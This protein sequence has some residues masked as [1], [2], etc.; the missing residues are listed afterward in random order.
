MARGGIYK[1]EVVRARRQLLAQGRYPSIDAIR[2][3]LG[4]TGSKS[5]IQKYLKEIEEDEGGRATGA[6]GLSEAIQGLSARLAEQLQ[7]E[8]DQR[9]MELQTRHA[10]EL[11]EARESAAAAQKDLKALTVTL[12]QLR[13]AVAERDRRYDELSGRYTGEVQARAQAQQLA[14]DVHLQLEAESAFRVSLETKYADA[15]RALEHFREAAKE[16]RDAES[17]KHQ[18]QLEYFQVEMRRLQLAL[19]EAQSTCARANEER[20]RLTTELATARREVS[21]FEATRGQLVSTNEKL[22]AAL[23]E[24]DAARAALAAERNRTDELTKQAAANG[25]ELRRLSNLLS[26]KEAEVAAA[27]AREE[28]VEQMQMRFDQQLKAQLGR[29]LRPGA[30]KESA[31]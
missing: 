10:E 1:S 26:E 21:Q 11:R 31:V 4:N 12:E 9:V 29:L 17:R 20:T 23:Q 6:T 13:E 19:N 22:T 8:A 18:S 16:Q 2:T 27:K 14:T 3:E 15:R 7:S 30:R 24:R 25:E 28:A 5:T